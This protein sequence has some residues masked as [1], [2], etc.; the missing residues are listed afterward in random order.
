[1]NTSTESTWI[2]QT[3][4]G[5]VVARLRAATLLVDRPSLGTFRESRPPVGRGRR[6]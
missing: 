3:A 1:M 6:S 2:A 5:V 4:D